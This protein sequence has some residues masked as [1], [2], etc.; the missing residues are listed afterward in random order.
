MIV[1]DVL[2]LD[3]CNNNYGRAYLFYT[4][5]Q[6]KVPLELPQRNETI[7]GLHVTLLYYNVL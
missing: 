6:L 2:V 4:C 7:E 3:L 1:K 5:T